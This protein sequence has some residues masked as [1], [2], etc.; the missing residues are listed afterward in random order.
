[1]VFENQ[2]LLTKYVTYFGGCVGG[3]SQHGFE[4]A[5]R[6]LKCVEMRIVPQ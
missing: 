5:Y 1:M 6:V 4:A 2:K 3:V